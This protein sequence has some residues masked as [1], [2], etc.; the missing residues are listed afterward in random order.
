MS[1]PNQPPYDPFQQQPAPGADPYH[2]G[3]PPDTLGYMAPAAGP[4]RAVSPIVLGIIGII[5]AAY[6]TLCIGSGLLVPL[7]GTDRI[8]QWLAD[9]GSMS[10][11]QIDQMR[12]QF[13]ITPW[14]MVQLIIWVLLGIACW[15]GAIGSLLRMEKGR[16]A[17][18]F[19]SIALIAFGALT[20]G[21][22]AAQGFPSLKMQVEAQSASG[23]FAMP[24][25]PLIAL[26]LGC[27]V[28]YA[29]YPV[30]VLWFYTRPA[31][32]AWFRGEQP[33]APAEGMYY[34]Q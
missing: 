16:I 2:A 31:V 33:P 6:N 34:Q 30:C 19:Y 24:L 20:H 23:G 9:L 11:E 17:L 27:A 4:R 26:S 32:K 5:Y 18:L 28:I 13:T 25:G 12:T 21:I 8:V 14:M 15:F 7:I 10:Q 29:I 22:E 3:Y 1:D